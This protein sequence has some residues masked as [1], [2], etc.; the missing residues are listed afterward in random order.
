M[1]ITYYAQVYDNEVIRVIAADQEFVDNYD[2]GIIGVWLLTDYYTRGNVH[3]GEN[4]EP[5]GGTP[6]RGNYAGVG[7]SYDPTNDVFIAPKP[8]KNAIL[9]E[10]T[11]TWVPPVD[12]L[13]TI[14]TITPIV[15]G[16]LVDY[17]PPPTPP[18]DGIA[19]WVYMT[20]TLLGD[21]TSAF[22]FPLT[23]TGLE[24]GQ[25][26]TVNV[27]YVDTLGNSFCRLYKF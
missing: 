15:N 19:G 7:F 5:D 27:G 12:E 10:S 20:S 22:D 4:G 2:D 1:T 9:D 17:L 18:E 16:C 6:I 21:Y 25:V 13:P 24:G 14:H 23:I 11:W 3:Y 26:Y 8:Y